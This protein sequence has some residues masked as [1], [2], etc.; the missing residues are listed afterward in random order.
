MAKK[1]LLVDDDKDFITISKLSIKNAG[2]VVK[3][4]R[5]GKECLKKARSDKPDLILL[6]VMLPGENGIDVCKKLKSDVKTKSIPVI[7]LTSYVKDVC[8]MLYK[9]EDLKTE[10]DDYIRKPVDYKKLLDSVRELTG[11]Y[12]KEFQGERRKKTG[13]SDKNVQREKELKSGFTQKREQP[14]KEPY[15]NYDFVMLKATAEGRKYL[16]RRIKYTDDQ[17]LLDFYNTLPEGSVAFPFFKSINTSP[18]EFVQE[19]T[20]TDCAED[21]AIGVFI[22][23]KGKEQI[24]GIGHYRLLPQSKKAELSFITGDLLDG[25]NVGKYLIKIITEIADKLKVTELEARVYSNNKEM[26]SLFY[27]LGYKVTY[28]SLDVLEQDSCNV[29]M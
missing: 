17:L 5:N 9:H 26:L 14:S 20:R 15:F 22:Q 7:L 18:E 25:K 3:V 19:L 1:I 6:D 29:M 8:S 16:F 27:D 11:G 10:A 28:H 21:I 13:D 24:I 4:A 23:E 2:Y 12:H